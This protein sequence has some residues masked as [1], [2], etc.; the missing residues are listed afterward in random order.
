MTLVHRCP[1]EQ[2]QHLVPQPFVICGPHLDHV[3]VDLRLQLRLAYGNNL[4]ESDQFQAALAMAVRAAAHA[5][6]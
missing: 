5:T 1:V 4:R 6:V 2:C 3:P